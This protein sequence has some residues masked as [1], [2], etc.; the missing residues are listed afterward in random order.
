M[1]V[2]VKN[3][4]ELPSL[5]PWGRK[6][7]RPLLGFSLVVVLSLSGCVSAE[8]RLVQIA[9]EFEQTISE[10]DLVKAR[11]LYE[12]AYS[13]KPESEIVKPLGQTLVNIELSKEAFNSAEMSAKNGDNLDA[14]ELFLEV[15][16][17]DTLRFDQAST[18]LIDSVKSSIQK[19]LDEDTLITQKRLI[20]FTSELTDLRPE[21]LK[22]IESEVS[23]LSDEYLEGAIRAVGDDLDQGRFDDA[24][25]T[26]N[27]ALQ[28]FPKDK[29]LKELS[30]TIDGLID[31]Q[32]R[33][34]LS[35]MYKKTDTFEGID[36]YYDRATYSS[37]AG[38]KF[39]LYVGKQKS[40]KPWLRLQMMYSG[41]DWIFWENLTVSV[42]GE[43]F[44]YNPG[45]YEVERNND[46]RVWEWYD[47]LADSGDI[48]MIEKIIKSQN[49]TLR[50]AGETYRSDLVLSSAQKRAF[51]NVLTA[52]KA[53]GG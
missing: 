3:G 30:E 37:Y 33:V 50:F 34:A 41:S 7:L 39:F 10:D 28:I 14:A 29:S 4:P 36:W 43:K 38:N 5:N 18:K 53:L 32:K 20:E 17:E 8:D 23:K 2:N 45:Y 16:P 15:S 1:G 27:S 9:K 49:T 51:A 44:E 48:S 42:D 22:S 12:E 26:L 35:A 24:K 21:L 31:R 6:K 11:E 52:Y 25:Y 13:L 47:V 19:A 46:T 40:G